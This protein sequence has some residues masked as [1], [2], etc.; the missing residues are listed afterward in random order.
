MA[1][2]GL[3]AES[4]LRSG[5]AGSQGVGFE[6]VPLCVPGPQRNRVDRAAVPESH[7]ESTPLGDPHSTPHSEEWSQ[8]LGSCC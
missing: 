3:L 6:V 4:R 1:A 2:R 5:R 8:H 7:I